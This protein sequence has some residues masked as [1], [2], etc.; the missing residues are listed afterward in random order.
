MIAE[1]RVTSFFALVEE[2]RKKAVKAVRTE[3]Q[4]RTELAE[5]FE[6]QA[7]EF[8]GPEV[9]RISFDPRF[10]ADAE[11]V[12]EIKEFILPADIEA[13]AKSPDGVDPLKLSKSELPNLKSVFATCYDHETDS[14]RVLFQRSSRTRVLETGRN[15]FVRDG[16]FQRLDDP[17]LT[18][19]SCLVAIF[20][21]G[22]LLFRQFQ[23]VNP[24]ID[25]KEYFVEATTEETY[26]VLKHSIFI[27]DDPE[28]L[29]RLCDMS[30]RKR[31]AYI[32]TSGVLEAVSV[33][34]ICTG[35]K[36]YFED[37]DVSYSNRSGIDR[38]KLPTKKK[39]LKRILNYLCESYYIGDL[40]AQKYESNSHRRLSP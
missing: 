18:L 5:F 29:S 36:S 34:K 40:T 4:L 24:L 14:I 12:F 33:R 2:R 35:L 7:A 25:I 23:I 3:R 17:G 30:M 38:L 31:I 19:D 9:E 13:A 22:S 8:L 37:I 27:S 26:E 6:V 21:S 1:R 16:T 32:K 28:A 11:H 39:D 20:D 10:K 15:I